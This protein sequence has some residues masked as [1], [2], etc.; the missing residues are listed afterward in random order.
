MASG[1][2]TISTAFTVNDGSV[3]PGPYLQAPGFESTQR[4]PLKKLT[5]YIPSVAGTEATQL[6]CAISPAGDNTD[7][8]LQ[9]MTKEPAGVCA[10]VD[11]SPLHLYTPS[12]ISLLWKSFVAFNE[13]VEQLGTTCLLSRSAPVLA[14]RIA[15]ALPLRYDYVLQFTHNLNAQDRYVD[16]Y[17]GMSLSVEYGAYQYLAAPTV[18]AG[19]R[20]AYTGTGATRLF[21]RRRTDGTLGFNAFNDS[22]RSTSIQFAVP[23]QIGGLWD[24]EAAGASARYVRLVYPPQLD[25]VTVTVPAPAAARNPVLLFATTLANMRQATTNYLNNGDPGS[26]GRVAFFSGRVA[27]YPEI[28]VFI[29]GSPAQVPLG[30]T[31]ADLI[32]SRFTVSISEVTS[33]SF[34]VALWRWAEPSLQ[35]PSTGSPYTYRQIQ[36]SFERSTSVSPTTGLTQWDIPLL[37][38]DVIRFQVASFLAEVTPGEE[39]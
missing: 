18:A 30:T 7:F 1:N 24:L 36:V 37:S 13:Q 9:W 3:A 5:M 27:L 32:A 19:A 28:S 17:P 14:N 35:D 21:L 20:N 29:N 31:L 39:S 6:L 33:A 34:G 4:P 12:D 23:N 38:G 16:L 25:N 10:I 22:L 2:F 8:S 15:Q 11:V 26:A